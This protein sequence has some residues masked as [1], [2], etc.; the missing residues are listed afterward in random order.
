[1]IF[2]MLMKI[3]QRA[4]SVDNYFMYICGVMPQISMT[5]I[6]FRRLRS[7]KFRYGFT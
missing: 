2:N 6:L 1:M 4:I 3:N 5:E 7:L